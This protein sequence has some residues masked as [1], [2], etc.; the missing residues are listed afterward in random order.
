MGFMGKI[1][2]TIALVRNLN[3]GNKKKKLGECL[4]KNSPP[5]IILQIE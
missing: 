1:G 3:E 4:E 2:I 5:Q